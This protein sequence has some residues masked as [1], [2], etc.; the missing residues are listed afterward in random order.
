MTHHDRATLLR[1]ADRIRNLSVDPAGQQLAEDIANLALGYCD[2]PTNR[3]S[4]AAALAGLDHAVRLPPSRE[5]RAGVERSAYS[6]QKL[7]RGYTRIHLGQVLGFTQDLPPGDDLAD[8]HH[9]TLMVGLPLRS[10]DEQL[11]RRILD[12]VPD[13]EISNLNPAIS[14]HA[15]ECAHDSHT[16]PADLR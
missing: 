2:G 13:S 5:K 4:L 7:L 15:T 3:V 9:A 16:A 12:G 14:H 1:A 6:P 11:Q 10:G 8:I